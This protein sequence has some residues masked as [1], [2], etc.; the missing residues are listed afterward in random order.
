MKAWVTKRCW[1]KLLYGLLSLALFLVL[2]LL[3]LRV[4]LYYAAPPQLPSLA[5]VK[6]ATSSS[7]VE[8]LDRQGLVLDRI[9]QDFNK[10]QGEWLSLDEVSPAFI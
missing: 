1:G 8:V 7:Y 3:A 6:A 10:R 2:A 4:A 9:R 5:E